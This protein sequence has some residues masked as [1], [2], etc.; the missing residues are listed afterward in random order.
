[1]AITPKLQTIHMPISPQ[2]WGLEPA[3]SRDSSFF[4]KF[5]LSKEDLENRARNNTYYW[6]CKQFNNEIGAFHG[7]Y[8]ARTRYFADPQNV[9]LIAPFQ[10]MAAFDRYQD[11]MLLDMAR[12]S[13]D[14]LHVNLAGTHPMSLVL[15]GILDNIKRDQLWTK[16]AA[17]Y[18]VLNLGLWERMDN[19]VYLDR[20]EQ[21]SHF[22]LQSQNHNF[23]P[24]YDHW[25]E[26][27]RERGWQSFGR[28]I[29][30]LI[31]LYEFTKDEAWL[32]RAEAWAEYGLTLQAENG[33]FYLI[34]NNYYSSDIAAPEILAFLRMYLRTKDE[35]FLKAG[36]RFADWH[37]VMQL[38]DGSW[39][40]SEDRWGV[41]VTKYK[42]PGDMPNIAIA[43]LL[44][45]R[46]TGKSKYIA[47]AI[48]ALK[49]SMSQQHLPDQ[50]FQPYHEDP[51]TH[52]GFWSWDPHYDY[53]MSADQS[54]HHARGFWFFMDYM[55]SF[56]EEQLSG[57]ASECL[58]IFES[59][60]KSKKNGV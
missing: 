49:Y 3:G 1:M 7:F 37:L 41:A 42:G 23:S 29:I 24:K 6:L 19:E 36:L 52:W 13:A 45:H 54:T 46:T 14:W 25:R 8:D 12:K 9:N 35:R 39:P 56:S 22:L 20:A 44:A 17:D 18:V 30:A 32:F 38:A 4:S 31:S 21:S 60:H 26:E 16:Y 34:N 40:L 48:K 27:W 10:C 47:S 58:Q 11:E 33:C 50:N 5:G 43:M 28:V 53:T 59:E 51:N 55:L 2:G 57:I 15:G